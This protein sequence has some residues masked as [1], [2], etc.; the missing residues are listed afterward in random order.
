MLPHSAAATIPKA[1]LCQGSDLPKLL[2][3]FAAPRGGELKQKE[4]IGNIDIAE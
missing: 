3:S 1:S 4:T 2:G